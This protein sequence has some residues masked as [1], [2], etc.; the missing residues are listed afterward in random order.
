MIKICPNCQ[1]ENKDNSDF[2][3]KC[4][5]KLP[6]TAKIAEQDT[7][8]Q[9]LFKRWWHRQSSGVKIISILGGCFL[10]IIIILLVIGALF[11]VTDLYL[12]KN[13]VDLFYQNNSEDIKTAQYVLKGKTDVNAKVYISSPELNLNNTEIPVDEKG[14]FEYLQKLPKDINELHVGVTAKAPNKSQ[15]EASLMYFQTRTS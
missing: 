3:Q 1:A 13:D 15:T 5:T 7:S 11:P 4:G 9:N 12:E 8:P 2:C 6:K 14:N 10:G